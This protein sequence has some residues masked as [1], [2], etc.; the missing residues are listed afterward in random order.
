MPKSKV[1]ASIESSLPRVIRKKISP[2]YRS[3][4]NT[5]ISIDI[6]LGRNNIEYKIDNKVIRLKYNLETYNYISNIITNKNSTKE[7]VPLEL[8]DADNSP[9]VAIDVGGHYGIYSVLL[10]KLNPSADLYVFE[11]DEYNRSVLAELMELNNIDTEIRN[12]VVT[13]NTGTVSFYL[14][15]DSGSESHSITPR[16]E[17][18]KVTIPSIALSDVI[19]K[20]GADSAILKIDAEGGEGMIINDLVNLTAVDLRGIVELHPDKLSRQTSEVIDQLHSEFDIVSFVGDSSPEHPESSSI[21][22]EYNR[23]IYYFEKRS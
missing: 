9:D 13:G 17:F 3:Y 8:I 10:G 18:E 2:I 15:G 22:N 16:E 6:V 1:V 14:D 21:D 5:L 11:P 20:A 4:V 7:G 23:P 19:R 12:E